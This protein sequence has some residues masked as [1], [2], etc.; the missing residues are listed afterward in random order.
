MGQNAEAGDVDTAII[1]LRFANGTIGTINNSR[2]AICGY[3][4]RVEVFGSGGMVQA[5][6]NT[7]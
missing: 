6:N 2:K 4:Q 1:T 5:A 7:P 3:D